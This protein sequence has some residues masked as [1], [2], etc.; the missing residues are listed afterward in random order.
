[1]KIQSNDIKLTQL[2][3]Q[4]ILIPFDV[5]KYPVRDLLNDWEIIIGWNPLQDTFPY[6]HVSP[7]ENKMV[8]PFYNVRYF[9]FEERFIDI[10]CS[11][12]CHEIGHVWHFTEMPNAKYDDPKWLNYSKKTGYPLDF[13]N[14]ERKQTPSFEGI[15][16]DFEKLYYWKL[17]KPYFELMGAKQTI[18]YLVLNACEIMKGKVPAKLLISTK[19]SILNKYK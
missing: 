3:L 6:P 9:G 11:L 1:M 5:V 7:S 17:P 8:L 12:A 14:H 15:G 18:D 10:D 4:K 2:F 19:E 13:E 16:H